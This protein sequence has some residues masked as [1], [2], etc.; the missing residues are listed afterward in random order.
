MRTSCLT[1]VATVTERPETLGLNKDPILC[2]Y[3]YTVNVF[4]VCNVQHHR[5]FSVIKFTK[6]LSRCINSLPTLSASTPV[7]GFL[8][9]PEWLV[10]TW[11]RRRRRRGGT[12]YSKCIM[13]RGCAAFNLPELP[14]DEKSVSLPLLQRIIQRT[15]AALK[16]WLSECGWAETWRVLLCFRQLNIVLPSLLCSS[17]ESICL[18]ICEEKINTSVVQICKVQHQELLF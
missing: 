13:G 5:S 16:N 11:Q 14:R 3:L 1:G 10:T 6:L 17:N 12:C 7:S 4:S 8:H 2:I 9:F 15:K 18:S